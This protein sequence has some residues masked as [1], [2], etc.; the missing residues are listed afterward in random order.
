MMFPDKLLGFLARRPSR[1]ATI[2]TLIGHSLIIVKLEDHDI[3]VTILGMGREVAIS[4][5]IRILF[6]SHDEPSR[7]STDG[8]ARAAFDL[9]NRLGKPADKGCVDH[10]GC[11]Y[12]ATARPAGRRDGRPRALGC[13]LLDLRR[14]DACLAAVVD[15]TRPRAGY[16]FELAFL[17]QIGFEFRKHAEHIEETF[18]GCGA[19][20]DGRAASLHCA[21]DVLKVPDAARQPVDT[22]NQHVA[23]A[24]KVPDD[25]HATMTTRN[26]LVCDCCPYCVTRGHQQLGK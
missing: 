25:E 16:A 18:A 5:R 10:Y 13:H 15:A 7:S 1:R 6:K 8:S 14:I 20:V 17:A 11:P 9:I 3:R 26:R 19:G 23:L 22:R 4:R 21:H 12:L 24:E 2:L